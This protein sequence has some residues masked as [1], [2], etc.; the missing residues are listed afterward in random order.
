MFRALTTLAKSLEQT[1]G[2]VT[3]GGWLVAYKTASV[4]EGEQNAADALTPK[5]RLRL[6]ERYAY[7]LELEDEKLDRVLYIYEK[8]AGEGRRLALSGQ[9]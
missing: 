4:P 2:Q 5:L 6:R 7:D 8:P 3:H 9:R 1:A